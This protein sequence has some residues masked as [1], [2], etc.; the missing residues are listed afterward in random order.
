MARGK[1]GLCMIPQKT[2]QTMMIGRIASSG[3]PMNTD[4]LVRARKTLSSASLSI[5]AARSAHPAHDRRGG[6][7]DADA[8]QHGHGA[9][10]LHA[11]GQLGIADGHHG[12]AAD[13]RSH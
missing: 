9:A 3:S 6:E 1:K 7:D 4:G 8:D 10:P 2:M 11:A 12:D 5:L 13:H